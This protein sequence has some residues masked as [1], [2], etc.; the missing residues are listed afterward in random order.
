MSDEEADLTLKSLLA[1]EGMWV[2]RSSEGSG[3]LFRS[4]SVCLYFTEVY[5]EVLR[6]LVQAFFANRWRPMLKEES[7]LKAERYLENMLLVE[8]ESLNLEIIGRLFDVNPV[9]FTWEQRSWQRHSFGETGLPVIRLLRLS[10]NSYSALFS[11]A[12]R[13]A[14]VFVQNLTLQLVENFISGQ[15]DDC[16]NLN[17]D[18]FTNFDFDRWLLQSQPSSDSNQ[19][20]IPDL[21]FERLKF[22]H[23]TEKAPVESNPSLP[24][25]SNVGSQIV[26]LLRKRRVP[27]TQRE[28]EIRP[29][30]HQT[31]IAKNFADHKIFLKGA[32]HNTLLRRNFSLRGCQRESPINYSRHELAAEWGLGEGTQGSGV[33]HSP[34][35]N[36]SFVGL[37]SETDNKQEG[38]ESKNLVMESHGPDHSYHQGEAQSESPDRSSPFLLGAD[39]NADVLDKPRNNKISLR[40]KLLKKH[41]GFNGKLDLSKSMSFQE[42]SLQGSSR[43]GL[44]GAQ[45][46]QLEKG[47]SH[48]LLSELKGNAFNKEKYSETVDG[49]FYTGNLKFFDEKNGFGFFQILKDTEFEDVF[50]YKSE[51]DKA[52][53]R[54]EALKSLKGVYG[55]TFSFQIASYVVHNDRRKKAINIKLL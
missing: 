20:P 52:E 32:T 46:A 26:T 4:A 39:L 17:G 21:K 27:G 15:T 50:V 6:G 9:L 24:G 43:P 37:D 45:L 2:R 47:D 7:K 40:E 5:Q 22:G 3:S 19:K 18:V 33:K 23:P 11:D 29:L 30:P 34:L 36:R 28:P 1:E 41:A 13:D 51:F 12:Q 42:S 35:H 31:F 55:H 53:I 49:R 8:F 54:V 10:E 38:N 48:K 25:N 14:F 16:R 44:A